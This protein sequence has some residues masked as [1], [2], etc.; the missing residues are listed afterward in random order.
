MITAFLKQVE[1]DVKIRSKLFYTQ[2]KR[3]SNNVPE[4]NGHAELGMEE[5]N[6]HNI[7]Y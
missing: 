4:G 5:N 7:L 6:D 3:M 2:D 1:T